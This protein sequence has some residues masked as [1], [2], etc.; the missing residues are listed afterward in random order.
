MLRHVV[1]E[2]FKERHFFRQIFRIMFEGVKVFGEVALDVLNIS[3]TE[4]TRTIRSV[5]LSLSTLQ[6]RSWDQEKRGLSKKTKRNP[7]QNSR[8]D[9]GPKETWQKN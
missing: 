3:A 1:S 6:R 5:H 7:K 8:F 9:Y 2:V 4:A